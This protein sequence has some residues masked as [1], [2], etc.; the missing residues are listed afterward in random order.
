[1]WTSVF[2]WIFGWNIIVTGSKD[3]L[4]ATPLSVPVPLG[5][6]Q[7]AA[8]P[9][10]LIVIVA[11]AQEGQGCPEDRR[12]PHKEYQQNGRVPRQLAACT[13]QRRKGRPEEGNAGHRKQECAF[14]RQ[15][16]APSCKFYPVPPPCAT[17]PATKDCCAD[18]RSGC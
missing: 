14:C 12:Q 5:V 18:R 6:I 16:P 8:C 3:P 17:V 13:G 4:E 10:R 2:I 1:M 9:Q 7:G 11:P 15:A